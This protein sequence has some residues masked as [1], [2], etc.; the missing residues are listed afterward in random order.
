M[1]YFEYLLLFINLLII[2]IMKQITLFFSFIFF[3]V[4][5]GYSQVKYT[6]KQLK[7]NNPQYTQP[8]FSESALQVVGAF[9]VFTMNT[10]E[11]GGWLLFQLGT[12][13]PLK[14]KLI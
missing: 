12:L 5:S 13:N 11:G 9:N 7:I 4:L 3:G 1:F 14:M 10:T 6:A 2:I 8:F